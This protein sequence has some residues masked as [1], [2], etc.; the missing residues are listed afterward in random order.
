MTDYHNLDVV[1]PNVGNL[2][3]SLRDIGYTFELALA[4]ILDNSI[5]AKARHIQ[6]LALP[7]PKKTV[8]I[9]DDGKG[10]TETQLIEAMR[11]ASQN[12]LTERLNDD[13]GRFG[14]GLK[15]ASFS[16]CKKLTVA[17]KKNGHLSI[18]QWDLDYISKKNE[19]LLITPEISEIFFKAEAF[20]S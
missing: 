6:I 1:N 5:S 14:L 10:M 2:V 11:L 8:C 19:W 4:D 16:Q 15:T 7:E 9:L 18:K 17:S 13:L 3:N 20:R 12:P